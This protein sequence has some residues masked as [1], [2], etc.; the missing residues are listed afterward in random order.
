MGWMLKRLLQ[1]Q[2]NRL[3]MKN[4]VKSIIGLTML[5][6]NLAVTL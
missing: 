1:A 5:N 3:V 6:Q 2:V 4:E